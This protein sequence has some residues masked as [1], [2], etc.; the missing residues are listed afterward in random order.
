MIFTTRSGFIFASIVGIS[1]ETSLGKAL[2]EIFPYEN[3]QVGDYLL[4][5]LQG[6]EFELVNVNLFTSL[7][8]MKV[9]QCTFRTRMDFQFQI[10]GSVCEGYELDASSPRSEDSCGELCK[11]PWPFK[12]EDENE[13][14]NEVMTTLC[15]RN[16]GNVLNSVYRY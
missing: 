3:S 8:E 12:F 13:G 15:V 14:E 4:R 1:S 10:I 11:V 9:Y 16:Y 7:G 2:S 6:Q 5:S